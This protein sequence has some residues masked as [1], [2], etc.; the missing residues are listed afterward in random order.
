V[1][2]VG[3]AIDHSSIE[4]QVHGGVM[5]GVGQVLGEEA[6]YDA[7]TGQ[8]L[9]ASFLDYTMPRAD[10]MHGIRC[11][12]HNVPT[13]TNG[14]GAK[15]VGESGTSGSLPTVMNAIMNAVRPRGVNAIDMP[16]TPDK[17]WRALGRASG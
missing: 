12:E 2:D 11:D 10:W 14:L 8:L 13:K 3:A 15:G 17:L 5:Q 4:G 6:V 7:E 9:T 1:D 16:V